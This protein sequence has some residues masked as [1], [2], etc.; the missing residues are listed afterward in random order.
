MNFK[1]WKK[2]NKPPTL[3]E[4]MEN[5]AR[6]HSLKDGDMVTFPNCEKPLISGIDSG[7]YVVK[8]IDGTSYIVASDFVAGNDIQVATNI[9]NDSLEDKY[10]LGFDFIKELEKL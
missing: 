5:V 3:E 2:K 10:E 9:A 7:N 8:S 1:I 4:V 6:N